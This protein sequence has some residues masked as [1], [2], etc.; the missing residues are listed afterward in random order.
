MSHAMFVYYLQACYKEGLVGLISAA[1]FH[2]TNTFYF[3]HLQALHIIAYLSKIL[4][5]LDV[6]LFHYTERKKKNKIMHGKG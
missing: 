3:C 6:W 4:K 2:R 5:A 1:C